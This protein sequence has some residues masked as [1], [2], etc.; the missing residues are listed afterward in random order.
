MTTCNTDKARAA[1]SAATL[2]ARR[3]VESAAARR[4][5]K[6]KRRVL[7]NDHI[8]GKT[9][10]R[11]DGTRQKQTKLDKKLTKLLN[12][13]LVMSLG[14]NVLKDITDK[15]FDR[16]PIGMVSEDS[17]TRMHLVDWINS[18]PAKATLRAQQ[19][20]EAYTK[21]YNETL[22]RI[23]DLNTGHPADKDFLAAKDII[24]QRSPAKTI[25]TISP[26]L[27]L[28]AV[29]LTNRILLS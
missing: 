23:E 14:K 27:Y 20:R 9:K 18:D 12:R 11:F 5:I 19:A 21:V 6:V 16:L 13:G 28:K 10:E 8:K 4:G 3:A 15:V 22:E 25:P 2:A 17:A 26:T 1:V 24:R 29:R 7:A